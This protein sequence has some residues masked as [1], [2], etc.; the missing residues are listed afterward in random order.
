MKKTPRTSCFAELFIRLQRWAGLSLGL[1]WSLW[2]APPEVT[3]AVS[4]EGGGVVEVVATGAERLEVTLT[5]TASIGYRFEGWSGD[6]FAIENPLERVIENDLSLTAQF[7]PDQRD[8]DSDGL[9]NHAEAVVYGTRV[10]HPDTDG[11]GVSDGAEVIAGTDPLVDEGGELLAYEGFDYTPDQLLFLSR[12]ESSGLGWRGPWSDSPDGQHPFSA[13]TVVAGSLAHAGLVTEGGHLRISGASGDVRLARRLETPFIAAAGGSLYLSWIGQ[14]LGQAQDPITTAPPN[15]FPRGVDL[16]FWSVDEEIRLNLGNLSND[17]ANTWKVVARDWTFDTELSFTDEPHC[18]VLRI[19]FSTDDEVADLIYLWVDPDPAAP[20]D[21]SQAFFFERA[22]ESRGPWFLESIEYVGFFVGNESSGRPHG[23]LIVD[24]IRLGT[25]YRSVL[26]RQVNPL[27]TDGDDL[28]DTVETNTGIYLSAFETG[29]DPALFDSDG[30]GLGDG[31]EVLLHGTD[32]NRV[33]TDGDG[34]TD[35]AEVLTF[36]SNPLLPDSDGDTFPDA[37]EV[38]LS[39]L[40][41]DPAVDSSALINLITRRSGVYG[42]YRR[43]EIEQLVG[44]GLGIET[45]PGEGTAR[46]ILDLWTSDGLAEWIPFAPPEASVRR[47]GTGF[48]VTLPPTDE[49]RFYQLE[50]RS[51]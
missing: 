21:L 28:E 31:A 37:L 15:P 2:G 40:G 39:A 34:L 20:E 38:E 46:L 13:S 19:D 9:T 50:W 6:F 18:F 32:P 24:E 7:L 49:A 45:D 10:N 12:E 29:T 33:D 22:E 41:F 47:T 26:P 30:D 3:T 16:R 25:G 5:A 44:A 48:E 14:R 43:D 17:D 4:P 23:E 8:N 42:L 1:P 36:G 35:G 51:E 27:D 11:D